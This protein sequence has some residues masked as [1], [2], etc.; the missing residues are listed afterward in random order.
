MRT[1][2]E[3]ETMTEEM[4]MKK[5][6]EK[7]RRVDKMQQCQNMVKNVDIRKTCTVSLQH[8]MVIIM[9]LVDQ[10]LSTRVLL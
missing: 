6:R 2:I 5:E 8:L 7:E 1:I 9:M 3:E 10:W 4:R